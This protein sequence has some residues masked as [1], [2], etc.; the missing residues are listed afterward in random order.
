MRRRT[1]SLAIAFAA[2]LCCVAFVQASSSGITVQTPAAAA[3]VAANAASAAAAAVSGSSSSPGDTVRTSVVNGTDGQATHGGQDPM[4]SGNGRWQVFS[5]LDALQPSSPSAQADRE[6]IFVR[7]L[8]NNTTTQ[9][10]EGDSAPA[11]G[12]GTPQVPSADSYQPS[13]TDDGRYIS[14][15]TN[16]TN[17]VTAAAAP[18]LT[19]V[20]CDRDPNSNGTFDELRTNG[21][22]TNVCKPVYSTA[23]TSADAISTFDTPQL[24]G[25]ANRIVW[26]QQNGS[27]FRTHV[28]SA[29]VTDSVGL[30]PGSPLRVPMLLPTPA[31]CG[32][33]PS[34]AET[35]ETEPIIGDNGGEIF[36]TVGFPWGNYCTAIVGVFSYATPGFEVTTRYDV[37]PTGCGSGFL[38]NRT[39]LVGDCAGVGGTVTT[40]YVDTPS[41]N[42]FGSEVLFHYHDG[43]SQINFA[44][45]HAAALPTTDTDWMVLTR[46][47][48][49]GET[50]EI[51]SR[52]NAGGLI[53]SSVGAVSEDGRFL[54]FA[55]SDAGAHDGQ[56]VAG[57]QI[58]ARD[59]TI[60]AQRAD[61]ALPRL[62][63][64]LVTPS[65]S[66]C[67]PPPPA[68]VACASAAGRVSSI[69]LDDN[70]ARISFT[71]IAADLVPNDTNTTNPDAFV[72]TWQP[73]LANGTADLGDV[74]AGSS[75]VVQVPAQ[76]TSFGPVDFGT[77]VIGGDVAEFSEE[78]NTCYAYRTFYLG[79][80]CKIAIRFAPDAN[81]LGARTATVSINS[82]QY[83]AP[84]QVST[85]T[86]NV[87][88]NGP[89][90]A[91]GDNTRTS[92]RNNGGQSLS[93]GSQSMISGNGRWQV[94]VSDSNLTGRTPVDPA[95]SQP[96]NVFVRD[97]ADPQHTLQI[98]LHTNVGADP[99]PAVPRPVAVTGKP[100]GASPNLSSFQ[101]SISSDG[102]FV[103]FFTR[104]TDIVRFPAL[105]S[106]TPDLAL[107]VCDRDPTGTKDAA[108]NAVL[109][110]LRKGTQVP[111]YV[112]FPVQSGKL[113]GTD[114]P[115]VTIGSTPRLSGDGTRIG[116]VENVDFS[117]DRVRVATLSTPGGKLHAP[118]NFRYV[119]STIFGFTDSATR[120]S[121]ET[122]QDDP[123]L[124]EDGNAV[125]YLARGCA[126]SGC[127][128]GSAVIET[129][130]VSGNSF[131][132]DIINGD[133]PLG[134]AGGQFDPPAVSDDGNR[135]AFAFAAPN[136]AF[137]LV[138]VV[139]R[140]ASAPQTVIASR[141]NRGNPAAGAVPALSGDGRY[142]AF[143]T[144][145]PNEHNGV[146]PRGGN[147]TGDNV[148]C[149]IVARDLVKDEVRAAAVP[150]QPWVPSEIVS[151]S[152]AATCVTKL[153]PGRVCAADGFSTNP[154][155]DQ[156]GSE[157]GF[158]SD[159]AD[160]VAG[161]T[162]LNN[163]GE[164][165]DFPARDAFVHTWRPTL[166]T[167]P[168]S[169]DFGTVKLGDHVDKTFT[170]TESGFGPISFG[171]TK[172]AGAN[173]ADFKVLSATCTA[174]TLNDTQQCKIKIRFTPSAPGS[175][176]STLST[177]VG[178]NGYPRHNPQNTISYDP[179]LLRT[180]T[181]FGKSA[182]GVPDATVNPTTVN[183]GNQLPEK[184]PGVTKK[185]TMTNT[186]SSTLVVDNVVVSD[187]T[188][189]GASGDYTVDFADCAGGVPPGGSCTVTVTF[190]GHAVGHRDA[191]LVITDNSVGS[192]TTIT[193]LAN[194]PKPTVAANPGVSPPGRVVTLTGTGFAPN[195]VVDIGIKTQGESAHVKT[196]ALGAFTV[197]LVLFPSNSTG[198]RIITAH[199]NGTG[200]S[201]SA[202]GPLLV[203]LGSLDSPRLV[204]RH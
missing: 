21:S 52:N 183:F 176:G 33:Q 100:R 70:G 7:D 25:A 84:R 198:P 87:V 1:R 43:P 73:T 44:G 104:A 125:V 187:T 35:T 95:D 76:V 153:P 5:S 162:N 188:H 115:G 117:D 182:A 46:S 172:I 149:Q 200:A 8:K 137:S 197:G 168:A 141:D 40:N 53:N 116:W 120:N 127:T 42:A 126:F 30:N 136:D 155:I 150:P 94:F 80:S 29:A 16:A 96:E 10:S 148:N 85:L 202:N 131:R 78:G 161:D 105:P 152:V 140:T 39:V 9:L 56:D 57:A 181:G 60:D 83:P 47:T 93:G 134:N 69:S 138:Y 92:V 204:M 54:A 102:R 32:T 110:L 130:L 68:G 62:K 79:D 119:P 165:G 195:R 91:A 67:V 99:P 178:K 61:A 19:L 103:S 106:D 36:F 17:I 81:T 193:L 118:T 49:S 112:C 166:S 173:A 177:S 48:F 121:G 186:G 82:E 77:V 89:K 169:F 86:A 15:L 38:G 34:E 135:V 133:E 74:Q 27:A 180:V 45:P 18:S 23:T 128:P 113:F 11:T 124:T 65:V 147:C 71:S 201:I 55:T 37:V 72:R 156:T 163:D 63:G 199:S 158:D 24:A 157:I 185:V 191:V 4:I 108:G 6:N 88:P 12:D 175:R 64:A 189:P 151:S 129:D 203:V 142:L 190:V 167:T 111:N 179:A 3:T 20:V 31:G 107:V 75:T 13:I 2:A 114:D 164:G 90:S 123:T 14:F 154:S 194:I 159:A 196:D 160:I 174:R 97:L 145:Q 101:P 41:I 146:E 184:V 59:L 58:V 50:S 192:P 132:L 28:W 144:S 122:Q 171:T 22:L 143:Q 51:A 26:T 170:V 139:T 109:D 66:T 98:S